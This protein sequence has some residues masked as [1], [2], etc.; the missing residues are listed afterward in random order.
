MKNELFK[1][2]VNHFIYGLWQKFNVP[3]S[4]SSHF[5]SFLFF[6]LNSFIFITVIFLHV[7]VF[8]QLCHLEL[9][10]I[11]ILPFLFKVGFFLLYCLRFVNVGVELGCQRSNIEVFINHAWVLLR[12]CTHVKL[13][14][15]IIKAFFI[16]SG[17]L[18]VL[19]LV[20]TIY[21][22]FSK[23][24]VHINLHILLG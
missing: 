5:H 4:F 21:E 9:I 19:K 20:I 2:F 6:I 10:L 17:T 1:H 16:F 11:M 7:L 3:Y 18:V 13:F 12:N 14:L 24:H 22:L 8:K 15:L 23:F